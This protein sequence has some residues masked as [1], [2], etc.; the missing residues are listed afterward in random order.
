MSMNVVSLFPTLSTSASRDVSLDFEVALPF[1]SWWPQPYI[2]A[3]PG[4][5]GLEGNLSE[6]AGH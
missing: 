3:E 5:G 1:Y 4:Q 6:V 2:W